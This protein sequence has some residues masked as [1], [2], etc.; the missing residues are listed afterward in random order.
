MSGALG[1]AAAAVARRERIDSELLLSLSS[2]QEVRGYRIVKDD[3]RCFLGSPLATDPDPGSEQVASAFYADGNGSLHASLWAALAPLR[4]AATRSALRRDPPPRLRAARGGEVHV[5]VLGDTGAG[6]S[7]LLNAVVG[8]AKL[9]P[10]NGMRA[11]TAAIIELSFAPPPPDA[12]AD[13]A[14][15]GMEAPLYRAEV[16]LLPASAWAEEVAAAMALLVGPDGALAAAE[17]AAD[18]PAHGAWCKLRAVYGR[19]APADTLLA[20]VRVGALLGGTQTFGA[21]SAADLHAQIEGYVDSSNEAGACQ[22][23]PLV[24]LARRPAPELRI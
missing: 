23:W 6:K 24:K 5:V 21:A 4:A 20:D 7:S 17:P 12:S 16:Q 11:C 9:L 8:E 3:G 1:G 10:T 19:V 22:L 13:D 15:A 18:T 2:R 14:A